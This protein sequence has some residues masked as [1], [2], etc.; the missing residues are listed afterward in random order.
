M[1]QLHYSNPDEFYNIKKKKLSS[2]LS[3]LFFFFFMVG[4][5]FITGIVGI[6]SWE[7]LVFVFHGKPLSSIVF[8]F[9]DTVATLFFEFHSRKKKNPK[10]NQMKQ[11]IKTRRK[12]TKMNRGKQRRNGEGTKWEREGLVGYALSV[13]GCRW[14]CWL[15]LGWVAGK[16]ARM[17]ESLGRREKEENG[18]EMR[19]RKN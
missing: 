2:L 12:K 11:R 5:V 3:S 18:G 10:S 19:E 4:G 15:V 16:E 14:L 17:G 9:W 13:V 1:L 6:G 7:H 8:E